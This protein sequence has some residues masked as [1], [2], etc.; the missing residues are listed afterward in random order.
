MNVISFNPVSVKSVSGCI[1]IVPTTTIGA[2]SVAI[3]YAVFH[4]SGL[5]VAVNDSFST[6]V[7]DGSAEYH[8]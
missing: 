7:V 8:L 3:S 2:L 5:A 6:G 1:V 4:T